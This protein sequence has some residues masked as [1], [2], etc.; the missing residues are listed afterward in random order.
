MR[1]HSSPS[2]TPTQSI[3]ILIADRNRMGNQLL[4]ESLGRDPRFKIVAAV[5]PA[6][7]LS[8]V[9]NLQPDLALVSADFDGAA[10]KGLQVARTLKSRNPSVGIVIVLEASTRE[11]VIAAFRCGAAGVFSRTE[12]LSE[13]ASCIER[14][15]RGE[16][17]ANKSHSDFL[18]EAIRSTPSCDGIGA[19]KI[20]Q[21]S[22]RELQ[23]AE[24]AA[25]GETNKQI[26]DRLGLRE[27]TVKNYLF[28]VF[29]KLGVSNRFEL[30]FLLFKECNG[31]TADRA[32]VTLATEQGHPIETYLTAAEEGS[33]AAQFVVGL[34]H[35][36]GYCVEK[37]GLSAYYWLRLAETSSQE[38]GHRS[39]ALVEQLRSAVQAHEIEDV[40]HRISLAVKNNKLLQS[41][42]PDEFIK[43]SVGSRP[44]RVAI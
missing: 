9:T 35:L 42:H 12:S 19:G 18:L 16:I 43:R 15:S 5:T 7:V 36:E 38:L 13:L 17:G 6:E 33:V 31:S 14:V 22:P 24:R 44:L 37:N 40:E 25:Q 41:Q 28:H 21:L 32:A 26:A 23:V 3:R 27:H 2:A 11:S 39:R 8:V 4:A 34:A 1:L 30:L 29:E 20:D 10:K